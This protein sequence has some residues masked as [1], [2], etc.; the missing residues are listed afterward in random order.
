MDAKIK[1][2]LKKEL[3][4]V[5]AGAVRTYASTMRGA[6]MIPGALVTSDDE[7]KVTVVASGS[8]IILGIKIREEF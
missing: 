4:D 2:Q 6:R 1:R 5:I 7:G 8:G 3:L